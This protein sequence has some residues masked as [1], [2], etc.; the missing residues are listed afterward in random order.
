M[1][2]ILSRIWTWLAEHTFNDE[3]RYATNIKKS[4]RNKNWT[5]LSFIWMWNWTLL[6]VRN[7]NYSLNGIYRPDICIYQPFQVLALTFGIDEQV[8]G[9]DYVNR[10]VETDFPPE[11]MAN[12]F[13]KEMEV[14]VMLHDCDSFVSTLESRLAEKRGAETLLTRLC[15]CLKA[16]DKCNGV[17]SKMNPQIWCALVRRKWRLCTCKCLWLQGGEKKWTLNDDYWFIS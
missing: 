17:A 3:N 6:F 5:F 1:Q 9:D 2:T 12:S 11:K 14:E 8:H 13:Q 15:N 10:S 16:E 4:R 7:K